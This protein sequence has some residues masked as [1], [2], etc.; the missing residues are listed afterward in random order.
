MGVA[1]HSGFHHFLGDDPLRA[2]ARQVPRRHPLAYPASSERPGWPAAVSQA[3]EALVIEGEVFADAS[4]RL[5]AVELAPRVNVL[6]LERAPDAFD[7]NIVHPAS[8]PVHRDAHRSL[9]Q[10]AG[11]G[12]AGELAALDA[13]LSVKRR[14]EWR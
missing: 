5:A 14:F 7:E 3:P 6:M 12:R 11:E 4:L 13:L 2:T 10:H 1:C 9:D 8:P